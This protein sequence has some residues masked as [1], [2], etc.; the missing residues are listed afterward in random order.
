MPSRSED[1]HCSKFLVRISSALT[2]AMAAVGDGLY[3]DTDSIM[4]AR[5]APSPSKDS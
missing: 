4:V 3:E 1:I 5:E 2:T